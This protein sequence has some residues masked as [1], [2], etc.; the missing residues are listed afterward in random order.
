MTSFKDAKACVRAHYAALSKATP[1]T[2]ESVL[3]DVM[4][5]EGI[6]RGFHPFNDQTGQRPSRRRFGPRFCGPCH[7]SNAAKISFSRAPT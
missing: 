7:V 3:A 4:P 2:V 1:E 6:W 5:E